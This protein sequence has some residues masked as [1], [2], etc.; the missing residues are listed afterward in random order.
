MGSEMC[1]RDSPV[2]LYD[3]PGR[4]AQAISIET[5]EAARTIPTVTS[6]KHATGDPTATVALRQ[7]G[8]DVY[9]GDDGLILGYLAHGACG[10]VSVVGHAAGRELA[11]LMSQFR[12]GDHEGALTA[13]TA[14]V[15]A[16][17]AV[18]GVANYGATTAKAALEL[19]GVLDNRRVRGPLVP[20]DDNE[21]A[22]L[23]SGLES[24]GLL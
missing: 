5:Y 6:V 22:A 19:L 2:M 1:I 16:F 24:A 7:L 11:A 20:L 3:V 12:D 18:M 10:L 14:L 8:Y 4:V 23:R 9:A 21:V 13:Y 15:P 17:A